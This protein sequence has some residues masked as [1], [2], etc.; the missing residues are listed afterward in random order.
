M[1]GGSA[2][3]LS[4]DPLAGGGD[5]VAAYNAARDDEYAEIVDRC[6]GFL[7]EIEEET[8][9]EH[10]TYGEL[11]ENDEDLAKLRG[12]YGKVEARDRLGAS[13]RAAAN[14]SL[15]QCEAALAAFADT[16]YAVDTES[17]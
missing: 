16:V 8:A 9:K 6:H 1:E 2:Q 14:K 15:E 7:R 10:F 11:E 3:L 12:W 13:G 4:A 5:L 17:S